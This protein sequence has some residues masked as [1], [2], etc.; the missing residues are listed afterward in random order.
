MIILL[1]SLI[2]MT[3]RRVNKIQEICVNRKRNNEKYNYS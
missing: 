2:V 1:N 3:K